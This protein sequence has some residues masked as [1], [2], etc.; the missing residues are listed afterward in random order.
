MEKILIG[1]LTFNSGPR[2]RNVLQNITSQTVEE[3]ELHIFDDNSTDETISILHEFSKDRRVHLHLNEFNLGYI[4]NLGNAFK[5]FS[6]QIANVD[7]FW[8]AQH[9]DY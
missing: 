8:F 1:M 7:F 4:V 5:Y 3:W 9:D 2:L 6:K